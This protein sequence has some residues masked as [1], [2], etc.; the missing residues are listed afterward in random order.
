MKALTTGMRQCLDVL[1]M[2]SVTELQDPPRIMTL[3]GSLSIMSKKAFMPTE[4]LHCKHGKTDKELKGSKREISVRNPQGWR[5]LPWRRQHA[6]STLLHTCADAEKVADI[7]DARDD[8]SRKKVPAK[9]SVGYQRVERDAGGHER[10]K[11][12]N[13]SIG[14]GCKRGLFKKYFKSRVHLMAET[15]VASERR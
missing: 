12:E 5:A 6:K 13:G 11:K 10:K 4:A 2:E 14:G 15:P 9:R 3:R 7:I 8:F 1:A